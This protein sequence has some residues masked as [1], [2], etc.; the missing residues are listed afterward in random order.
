MDK[1]IHQYDPLGLDINQRVE[2]DIHGPIGGKTGTN[3]V[4]EHIRKHIAEF[5]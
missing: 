5:W 1:V 4:P 2:A 3:N